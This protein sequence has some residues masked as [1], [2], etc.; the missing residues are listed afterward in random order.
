MQPAQVP[1]DTQVLH[2]LEGLLTPERAKQ[3][4]ADIEEAL[5][6]RRPEFTVGTREKSVHEIPGETLQTVVRTYEPNGRI[7]F[8]EL[9]A[10]VVADIDQAVSERLD[11]I[12]IA[13]PG[14]TGVQ[15]WFYVSYLP[16]Q[17]VAPHI[18][19]PVDDDFPSDVKY[20]AIGVTLQSAK[21]GGEF[22]VETF[23][24]AIHWDHGRV[25][26]GGDMNSP[27]FR[28]LPRTRWHTRPNVGDAILWG[29]QMVHGTEPVG[30]GAAA[31][32]IGLLY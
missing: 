22:F 21:V 32:L 12:R 23:G 2:S 28:E 7:E 24:A 15:G 19:Y 26:P 30:A 13:Y 4:M 1:R 20:A 31:K 29:T 3:L 5:A 16:G 17:H 14:A 18:D 10:D 9:P 27:W 11:D 25:R 6:D 8:D